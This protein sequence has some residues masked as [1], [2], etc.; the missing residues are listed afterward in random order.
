M[1]QHQWD[2]DQCRIGDEEEREDR[3]AE[4]VFETRSPALGEH[5]FED[6]NESR[7]HDRTQFRIRIVEHI[8]RDRILR[9]GWVEEYNI[10]GSRLRNIGEDRISEIT[11][12]IDEGNTAT[13]H[14]IG[15][16]HILEERRL[17]HTRL[18]DDIGM[19]SSI[20]RLDSEFLS[21]SS[22]IRQSDRRIGCSGMREIMW[23]LEPA[24]RDPVNSWSPDIDRRHM[25]ESRELGD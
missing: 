12:W 6:R 13:R 1:G 19:T 7:C 21:R 18:P 9:I 5:L 22:E 20:D 16:E 23:W 8:E 4:D 25:H 14:D 2:R 3:I 11:M 17:A 24:S 10:V 15:V